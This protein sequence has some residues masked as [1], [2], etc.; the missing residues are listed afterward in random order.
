MLVLPLQLAE[1]SLDERDFNHG[2]QCTG[3]ALSSSLA[4][5]YRPVFGPTTY[6]PKRTNLPTSTRGLNRK[7]DGATLAGAEP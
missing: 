4:S 3:H 6:R 7:D 5:D 1:Y 2:G